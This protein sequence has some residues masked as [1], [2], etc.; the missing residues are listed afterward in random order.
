MTLIVADRVQETTLA[1]G[2]SDYV[3]LGAKT[4]FQSF[5]AVMA[6]SD[7]T[8]YAVT[9]GTAW[10]VGLG[11]YSTVGPTMARTTILSSSNA[12]AAVSWGVGTKD[13]FLSYAASKSVYL[14]AS[15]NLS[16]DGTTLFVDATNDRVGIGTNTPAVKEE[17]L[18]N[19]PA[20][21]QFIS[22]AVSGTTLDVTSLISGALAVGQY[23]GT[24]NGRVRIIALGTGTGGVGTYILDTD[25]TGNGFTRS[26]ADAP[27]TMRLGNS[28]TVWDR[29]IPYGT[30]EFGGAITNSGPRGYI[31][32]QASGGGSVAAIGSMLFGVGQTNGAAPP[33]T[34]MSL[35]PSSTSLAGNLT[36][37]NAS[38]SPRNLTISPATLGFQGRSQT[39]YSAGNL[40]SYMTFNA[41]YIDASVETAVQYGVVG[42]N[43]DSSITSGQLPSNFF[44]Q[45][46][47]ASG[48]LAE[49]FRID[50]DGNVG[51]GTTAPAYK[52]DVNGTAN[53]TTMSIGGTAITA[54]AAELNFV[55]GV[56]SNIQTQLDGKAPLTG[57]G[58]SGTWG[59]SI[60]GN[61]ATATTASQIDGIDFRN[62][63]S[64]SGVAPDSITNNGTGYTT[65]V[66]LFGQTDG[67][68]YSQAYNT[69]WVHQI[70]GDYRTGQ[71]AIRGKNSGT[72]QAWRSVLDSSNYTS[73]APTLTGSG[74][75]GTWGISVTG[76]AA[77]VTTI[78]SA[79]VGAATAG[80]ALGAVG[81][82]ALL[83]YP[84]SNGT[85]VEG[86]LIAGSSLVYAGYRTSSNP[87]ANAAYGVGLG[88]S[89]SGTWMVVGA[90][91]TNG[92]A[93]WWPASVFLRVS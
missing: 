29:N 13:I 91:R 87:P 56:T 72:W 54:T 75:S 22:N 16:V 4:G 57:A 42:Y 71:I 49:R 92:T 7:T 27:T 64:T 44:I 80:L 61:A 53:A 20:A 85:F 6:N 73:Y 40:L 34:A 37:G 15:G 2:T 5:G 21:A 63:D 79:Q 46:R 47:N 58:T 41:N 52:L 18:G 43:V 82:Y 30:V 89:P 62:G 31:Q 33:R 59:I 55:D 19:T 39:I 83:S 32:T 90:A 23:L 77:T 45:T 88:A 38:L 81:T 1:T 8:Y 9:D 28:A 74:A 60:S 70:F 35:G 69:S 67:A 10:E 76:N 12:G 48:T 65:T 24:P 14:D 66:S 26:Y 68:L 84:L 36:L 93:N 50:K 11:T 17:I 25:Q 51:I 86:T 3:L 78:T